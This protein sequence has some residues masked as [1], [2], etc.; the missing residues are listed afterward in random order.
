MVEQ[1]NADLALVVGH[2]AARHIEKAIQTLGLQ[3]AGRHTECRA[4]CDIDGYRGGHHAVV[5]ISHGEIGGTV[6]GAA[7]GKEP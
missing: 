5:L 3:I 2:I 1:Q 7:L 4:A 6:S